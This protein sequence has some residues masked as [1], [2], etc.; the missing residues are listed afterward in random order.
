MDAAELGV[1][2]PSSVAKL[3]STAATHPKK[4]PGMLAQPYIDLAKDPKKAISEHPVSTFLMFSRRSGF[5]GASPGRLRA[6]RVSRRS[7]GRRRR[8]RVPH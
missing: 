6:Q 2:T 8:Y 5:R 4:V 1:T 3:A 7:S